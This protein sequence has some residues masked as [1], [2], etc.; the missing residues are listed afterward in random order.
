MIRSAGYYNKEV[1]A[2][3]I[4]ALEL[5]RSIWFQN[6]QSPG[7]HKTGFDMGLEEVNKRRA[8][9]IDLKISQVL[10]HAACP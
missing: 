5:Y 3:R 8:K 4:H 2:Q 1:T 10:E 9:L 7:G 6:K